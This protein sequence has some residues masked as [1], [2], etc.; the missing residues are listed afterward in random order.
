[1]APDRPRSNRRDP[2]AQRRRSRAV[3]AVGVVVA[4]ALPVLL[5]HDVITDVASVTALDAG[6]LVGW[7]PW[8]LML[9]GLLCVVPITV[10]AVRSRGGRFHRPGSE[11]WV[12]WG[13]SLYLLGFAL[14]TQVAQL[15]DL[16]S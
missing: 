3:G 11:A 9:L 12:G 13:V 2:A 14:A 4:A 15:H 5:W 7:A 8:L 16:H 10:E 1:M 6:I